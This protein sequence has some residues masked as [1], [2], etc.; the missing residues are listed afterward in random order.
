MNFNSVSTEFRMMTGIGCAGAPRLE[1]SPVPPGF[2]AAPENQVEQVS[3]VLCRGVGFGGLHKK[4]GPLGPVGKFDEIHSYPAIRG[5]VLR[6]DERTAEKFDRI[7]QERVR[8]VHQERVLGDGGAGC[9][10]FSTAP[11]LTLTLSP[12]I[13]WERRGNSRRAQRVTQET[14]SLRGA[15]G[16]AVVGIAA[17]AAIETGMFA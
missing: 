10:A 4:G 6:A 11:H 1:S 8:A 16:V 12:P 17:R 2:L 9:Q 3:V 15:A 5:H 14:G 13:R 7:G